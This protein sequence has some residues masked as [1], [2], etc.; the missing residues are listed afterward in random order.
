MHH[1]HYSIFLD[2]T[3]E[4]MNCKD[5]IQIILNIMTII[6][7]I[8]SGSL[9]ISKL[10]QKRKKI[11]VEIKDYTKVY[12]IVQLYVFITNGSTRTVSISSI[13]ISQGDNG[14][15]FQCE[16]LP[17]T[18]SRKNSGFIKTPEFPLNLNPEEARGLFLEFLDCKDIELNEG[19]PFS[20]T[21]YTNRGKIET[22][23]T[24]PDISHYLHTRQ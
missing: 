12:N 3:D 17:K 16:L 24:L 7:F 11:R 14:N 2:W 20:L 4:K 9:G 10:L 8:V 6:S 23:L 22:H 13:S 15:Q 5:K 19:I 18:I 1:L 21:F